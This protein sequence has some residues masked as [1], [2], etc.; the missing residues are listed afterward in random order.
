[1]WNWNHMKKLALLLA[2]LLLCGSAYAASYK[3]YKFSQ[4]T[5]N[6]LVNM[7]KEKDGYGHGVCLGYVNG[8]SALQTK[9][10]IPKG[11]KFGQIRFVV[12][13]YMRENPEQLHKDA[14][15]LIGQSLV[16]AW[17]CR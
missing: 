1:M 12:L 8:V 5:G 15:M 13:K 4:I 9:A 3:G 17:P 2:I 6:D 7:C 14:R 10:C 16:V 11:V